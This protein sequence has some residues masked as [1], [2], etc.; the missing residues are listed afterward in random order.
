MATGDATSPIFGRG[1]ALVAGAL[2]IALLTVA[3]VWGSLLREAA[4]PNGDSLGRQ[5]ELRQKSRANLD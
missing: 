1:P 4:G 5:I 2:V 3:I